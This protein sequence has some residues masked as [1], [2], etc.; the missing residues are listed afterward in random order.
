MT[1]LLSALA[2]LAVVLACGVKGPP[3]RS[4]DANG[5]RVPSEAVTESEPAEE[6]PEEEE[7]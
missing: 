4:V 5:S 2:G 1:R 7:E 6:Q 3:V